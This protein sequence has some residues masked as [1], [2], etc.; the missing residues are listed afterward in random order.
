MWSHVGH[1]LSATACLSSHSP[2]M[3]SIAV[4]VTDLCNCYYSSPGKTNWSLLVFLS[5]FLNFIFLLLF[6]IMPP[7]SS[8]HPLD[9]CCSKEGAVSVTSCLCNCY[10][11]PG[12][13]SRHVPPNGPQAVTLAVFPNLYSCSYSSA[14]WTSNNIPLRQ[15]SVLLTAFIAVIINFV[16]VVIF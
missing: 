7:P 8:H 3:H 2:T 4:S 13:T 14:G 12:R 11:S 16:S 9:W 1:S 6:L 5:V 15:S 10:S